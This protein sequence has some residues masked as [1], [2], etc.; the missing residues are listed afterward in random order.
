MAVYSKTED[1]ANLTLTASVKTAAPNDVFKLY[2]SP[3]LKSGP[4][5]YSPDATYKLF[6]RLA[7]GLKMKSV[8]E[9][10]GKVHLATFSADWTGG[11]D[12]PVGISNIG[13]NPGSSE[14]EK[15]AYTSWLL[16]TWQSSQVT[17]TSL[18]TPLGWTI[19]VEVVAGHSFVANDNQA[20][21]DATLIVMQSNS[22]KT[23]LSKPFTLQIAS[24]GPEF[25]SV[26]IPASPV[27][28]G[29]S[30]VAEG[31][32]AIVVKATLAEDAKTAT[33]Q[34]RWR[35]AVGGGSTWNQIVP[36]VA[37]T[38]GKELAE[39]TVNYDFTHQVTLEFSCAEPGGSNWGAPFDVIV[40]VES[41]LLRLEDFVIKWAPPKIILTGKLIVPSTQIKFSSLELSIDGGT[42]WTNISSSHSGGPATLTFTH[43]M[44]GTDEK[45]RDFSKGVYLRATDDLPRTTP[46]Q[47]V[48][49]DAASFLTISWDGTTAI[50]DDINLG[51]ELSY[52]IHLSCAV[53]TGT[54]VSPGTILPPSTI[55]LLLPDSAAVEAIPAGTNGYI[56]FDDISRTF[57]QTYYAPG[58]RGTPGATRIYS[59]PIQSGVVQ[60]L[61]YVRINSALVNAKLAPATLTIDSAEFFVH[62]I[63]SIEPV[64]AVVYRP[65]PYFQLVNP[66]LHTNRNAV[67]IKGDFIPPVEPSPDLKFDVS[68]DNNPPH[69][70]TPTTLTTNEF[71]LSLDNQVFKDFDKDGNYTVRLAVHRSADARPEERSSHV[72]ILSFIIDNKSP[73]FINPY[74]VVDNG[75]LL[76][77]GDVISP[78]GASVPVKFVYVYWDHTGGTI[79]KRPASLT[80]TSATR[81]SFRDSLPIDQFTGA[82][83]P[84]V[85]AVAEGA[86]S[87]TQDLLFQSAEG[88][89]NV[90]LTINASDVSNQGTPL[91][92]AGTVAFKFTLTSLVGLRQKLNLHL[93]LGA[94]FSESVIT[95]HT[96]PAPGEGTVKI[97]DWDGSGATQVLQTEDLTQNAS[98]TISGTTA[99][100][101]V[102]DSELLALQSRDA[103][104]TREAME[105]ITLALVESNSPPQTFSV[106]DPEFGAIFTAR[107][108]AK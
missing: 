73:A 16:A 39:F 63:E 67:N 84:R 38:G 4:G 41:D 11:P 32:H 53:E 51:E 17:D 56:S 7:N 28:S 27:V 1:Y 98:F 60:A 8:T 94:A 36:D 29:K 65:A 92:N 2:V 104:I 52:T 9:T 31:T 89:L 12:V 82:L 106:V 55:D 99:L 86:P 49:F 70:V 68:V 72:E 107:L 95:A 108:I 85:E 40:S 6:V 54:P 19:E 48:K 81:W 79:N 76:A 87:Q 24:A 77:R 61:A 34:V 37:V 71:E 50:L 59:G 18:D 66:V 83:F 20:A 47:A 78:A 80:S 10:S 101:K 5:R 74:V 44:T 46:K 3:T 45:D 25:A 21:I 15:H 102:S 58:W 33:M 22:V 97:T 105:S 57:Q 100:G 62:K 96:A 91:I 35:L 69:T 14:R 64:K 23:A 42:T 13:W 93:T 30:V 103:T 90:A 75:N 26:T 43:D 88:L